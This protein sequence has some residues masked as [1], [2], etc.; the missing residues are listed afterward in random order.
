MYRM[1][2]RKKD[3]LGRVSRLCRSSGRLMMQCCGAAGMTLRSV[4][5]E[6]P[7]RPMEAKLKKWPTVR[8]TV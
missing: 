5:Q 3:G 1:G 8:R 6:L 2:E 4:L 7:F